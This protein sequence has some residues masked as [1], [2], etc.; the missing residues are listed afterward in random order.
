MCGP[1]DGGRKNGTSQKLLGASLLGARAER[2]KMKPD[3]SGGGQ[4][5]WGMSVRRRGFFGLY[6]EIQQ[7]DHICVLKDPARCC[8]AW[9]ALEGIRLYPL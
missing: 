1:R 4:S 8:A 3:R 2:G 6:P 9:R 7:H 5:I